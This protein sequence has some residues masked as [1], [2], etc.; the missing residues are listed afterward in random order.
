MLLLSTFHP[1]TGAPLTNTEDIIALLQRPRDALFTRD[2][3]TVHLACLAEATCVTHRRHPHL[4]DL[5]EAVEKRM[6][7]QSPRISAHLFRSP[8]K[9]VKNRIKDAT[10]ALI[11]RLVGDAVAPSARPTPHATPRTPPPPPP[12]SSLLKERFIDERCTE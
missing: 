4:P 12:P 2:A 3:A 8:P 6:G 9:A 10:A 11:P 1:R 7:P 5:A